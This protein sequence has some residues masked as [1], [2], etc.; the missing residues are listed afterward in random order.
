MRS[1]SLPAKS[2]WVRWP[3]LPCWVF[4]LLNV[5]LLLIL[6]FDWRSSLFCDWIINYVCIL[7]DTWLLFLGAVDVQVLPILHILRTRLDVN[8]W[9]RRAWFVILEIWEAWLERWRWVTTCL[10]ILTV[11]HRARVFA[12]IP[13][14]VG[15]LSVV[16]F[17]GGLIELGKANSGHPTCWW[18]ILVDVGERR[19]S[20]V[21]YGHGYLSLTKRKW[22]KLLIL[23]VSNLMDIVSD[24][25]L[26]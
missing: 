7:I 19:V 15:Y 11:V 3:G 13:P 23:V 17:N 4:I 21:I 14:W 2:A 9:L 5:V 6:V 18:L 25:D 10:R 8:W 12:G 22:S 24:R 16:G 26:A 1:L 20:R